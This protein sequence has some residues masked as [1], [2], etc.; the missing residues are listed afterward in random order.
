M[1]KDL[2]IQF[3]DELA[4]DYHLIFDNWN[5]AMS[6]QASTLQEI[7]K[8]YAAADASTI[9]DCACGIGTQPIGLAALGYH[10]W[11]TDLIEQ[12]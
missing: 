3:Y 7:I 4:D 8:T 9:L 11:G 12:N 6:K 5:E 10:V 2:N 1:E